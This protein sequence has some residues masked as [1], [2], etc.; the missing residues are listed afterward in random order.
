MKTFT[1]IIVLFVVA[2]LITAVSV[3]A[4][5]LPAEDAK[6]SESQKSEADLARREAEIAAKVA[7]KEAELAQKEAEAVQRQVAVMA[8]TQARMPVA[9]TAPSVRSTG[10]SISDV[11][12]RL[13][14]WP[15]TGS[16][17]TVLVIPSAEITTE[18]LIT[19][20]EDLNVM[21]RIFENNL[22][23][24]RI[25]PVGTSLFL[26]EDHAFGRLLGM[27]RSAMQSMYLQG[28]GVLFLMKVD[29]P[30]SP[31]AE[32]QQEE[33]TKEQEAEKTDPV[34]DQTRRRMYEP[35]EAGRDKPDEPKEKYDAEKVENL[36]T[37]LVQ[38]LKHAANIR[39]L[40]PDESVILTVAGSAQ[41][42]GSSISTV[43]VA[44]KNLIVT[45]RH[46]GGAV[47]TRLVQGTSPGD[48]G[49][50]SPAILV[51]RAKKSDIDGFAKGDLDAD[52]FRRRVSIISCPYLGAG[53]GQGD[54][55]PF[56]YGHGR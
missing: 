10:G 21:S 9:P 26:S 18:E 16:A 40:K 23:Q 39:N 54:S 11:R 30:L 12:R 7:Q 33:Q 41:T 50:S 46:D 56:Y 20:T 1:R 51:I 5:S 37:A 22:E 2:N 32:V 31:P 8:Q 28:Y 43:A 35:D 13:S 6:A 29:F 36:K 44:G 38:A 45:E 47:T 55:F 53:A 27:D 42:T 17:G 49:P 48:I 24:A 34:W 3:K 52:Q 14:R 25:S 4:Q 19:V 15:R